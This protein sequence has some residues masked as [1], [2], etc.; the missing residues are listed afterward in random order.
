MRDDAAAG[1]RASPSGRV[2]GRAQRARASFAARYGPW[3]LVAGGT[4]GIGAAFARELAARGLNLVLVARRSELLQSFARELGERY[5]IRLLPLSLD[6]ATPEGLSALFALTGEI[7]IGLLVSNAA[8]SPIGE[9]LD[10]LDSTHERLIDLN[11]RAPA[12]L[13]WRLGRGMAERGRGGIIFLSSMA[14]FQ[15]TALTAH[16]AASKAY[17]RVLAEG[18]WKELRPRGVD[19]LAC[20]AG[21]VRTPTLLRENPREGGLLAAPLMESDR[22]VF[23]TLRAL[24]RRATVIPGRT[25]RISSWIVTRLLPRKAAIALFSSGTRAM[26]RDGYRPSP[27]R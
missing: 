3:A 21:L 20:N 4:D 1:K 25:N 27:P 11:C 18:L 8:L 14:G 16:Y 23:E 17:V 9:F 15:G 19:V 7:E 2:S 10:H 13:A 24:G 6:L 26:Y 22:V 12:L 5:P